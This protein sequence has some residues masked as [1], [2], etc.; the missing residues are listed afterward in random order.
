MK[1]SVEGL[2]KS[3]ATPIKTDSFAS[4]SKGGGKSGKSGGGGKTY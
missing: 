3:S 2:P 1:G 4:A